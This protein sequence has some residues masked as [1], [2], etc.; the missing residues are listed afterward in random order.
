NCLHIAAQQDRYID[1]LDLML[2]YHADVNITDS[3]GSNIVFWTVQGWLLRREGADRSAYLRVL[4]KMLH[5][6]ADLDQVNRYGMNTR[7]WIE[8]SSADVQD[9]VSRW[10]AAQPR[11]GV[12]AVTTVQ[13]AFPFNLRYPE[14]V[15]EIWDQYVPAT[16]G[17]AQ[18]VQGE[19]L[20]AVEHLRDEA[21]H[22][23]AGRR[24]QS[25][26]RK[27]NKRQAL[28]VRDTLLASGCFDSTE[29]DRIRTHTQRLIKPTSTTPP[30]A[31]YDELVDQVCVFYSRHKEPIPL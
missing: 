29:G 8:A 12:H 26:H 20:R 7:R 23:A 11:A 30:D 24:P 19:L 16:G 18:T 25:S 27:A 3:D 15:R 6:G 1:A 10:E 21:H 31:L 14:L 17:P 22:Q 13:P 2:D 28:F 9:L 5:L 4:D